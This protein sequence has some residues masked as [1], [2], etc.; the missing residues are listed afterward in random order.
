MCALCGKIGQVTREH[1]PP[2][3]LYLPPRPRNTITVPV[4]EPCNHGYHLDDEHFRVYVAIGAKPGT[5]LWRLWKEKVVGSSFL[6]GGGLKGRLNDDQEKVVRHHLTVEPLR[7]LDNKTLGDEWLPLVQPFS[8]SRINAVV[9]KIV[10]CLHFSLYG[11]PL[12][13]LARLDVDTTPLTPSDLQLL[14]GQ[15]TGEVGDFDEFVFRRE[16]TG[17]N[18]SRWLMA[19]YGLHTFTVKVE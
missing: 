4:C 7:T 11:T 5:R 12:S 10:R 2:K 8:A 18:S 9:E 6:R 16:D 19:F 17:H 14:Y 3:N 13:K 1:V 15:R